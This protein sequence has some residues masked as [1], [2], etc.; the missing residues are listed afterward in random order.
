MS[1]IR[2]FLIGDDWSGTGPANVTKAYREHLP[3]NTL[4]LEERIKVKRAIELALKMKK[5]DCAF[6]SG[7]SRQNILGM[8]LAA[9][10]GIPSIYLMHGCV[11]FENILNKVP[12]DKMADDERE[13]MK[14]ADL[15]LG[16][17]RQFE[18]WLKDHYPK[19]KNKIMHLT[20]GIDWDSLK[21]DD[22][23]EE[24]EDFSIISV[25]GGMP[26]KRIV[27]ICKAIELLRKSGISGIKLTVAGAD[28]ADTEEINGFEFVENVGLVDSVELFKLYKKS[29]VFVQNSI[30]ETFG[31]APVEA[32]L[33]GCDV[34]L[35]K[36]CGV[37]SSLGGIKDTD[38]INDHE[39]I[40]EIAS[41]LREI[42]LKGNNSRILSCTDKE[43][44]S[45]ENRS[46]ELMAIAEKV[47]KQKKSSRGQH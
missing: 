29:K 2:L 10:R 9:M 32:L 6:F 1:G 25:G 47:V 28:G 35:S 40:G 3:K 17:S 30:F 5:A 26:R 16:V 43:H 34:L 12:N 20:N 37:L 38:V 18:T 46:K 39:D 33:S 13:M 41:K 19:Y 4:Y 15:I 23:E 44:T 8:K 7:H 36:E 24:R 45:W 21:V 31:L 27:N 11:E 14:A 42:M 22:S